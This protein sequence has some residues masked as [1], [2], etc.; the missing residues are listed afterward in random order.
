[1]THYA[2]IL[3]LLCGLACQSPRSTITNEVTP[4]DYAVYSAVLADPELVAPLPVPGNVP[5]YYS[6]SAFTAD[7][8][9]PNYTTSLLNDP[10]FRA[11]WLNGQA[12]DDETVFDFLERQQHIARLSA[13]SFTVPLPVRIVPR[14]QDAEWR[15]FDSPGK[16]WLA[17]WAAYP[18]A[19]GMYAFSRVGYGGS[20]RQALLRFGGGTDSK[21]AREW[22]VLLIFTGDK[23]RIVSKVPT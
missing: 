14:E 19:G 13:D 18:K 20:P 22:R 2:A 12:A 9:P 1:M 16:Y 23:W 17:F 6:V 21:N 3:V 5:E 4:T 10:D 11:G 15:A 7:P 8:F